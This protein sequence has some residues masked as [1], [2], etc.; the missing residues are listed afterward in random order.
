MSELHLPWLE[1]GILL[2][3]AGAL[4]SLR[5]RDPEASH[6]S[7]VIFSALALLCTLAAWVDFMTLSSTEAH[8]RWSLAAR[9]IG[10]HLF[11]IDEF[12]APLLPMAALICFVTALATLRTKVRRVSFTLALLSESILLAT[13]SCRQPWGVIALLA[14]GTLPPLWELKSRR[15]PVRNFALHMALFVGLLVAGWALVA[16]SQVAAPSALGVCLLSAALL[17]RSG[18]VPTHTWM[19]DLFEHAPFGSA[20]TFVTPIPG[21]YAAVRLLLPVAPNWILQSVALISLVTA[22][23]AAGMALV[24]RNARRFFC[25]VLLSHSSLVLVGL[26]L[27]TPLGLT[28]AL[29]L[30]ISVGLAL[31]GFGL[32]LRS[33]EA[34]IGPISLTDYHGLYEHTPT[35]AVFFLLTGLASIGFPGTIGFVGS[36]LLVAGAVGSFPLVG[37]AVVFAASLN[38]IA[39]LQVYFRV[40]TGRRHAASVSLASGLPERVAVLTLSLLI[41]AGGLIPQPGLMSRRKAATR[42]ISSRAQAAGISPDQIS[43]D[44]HESSSAVQPV[45]HLNHQT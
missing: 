4:R 18:I 12:S 41:L 42:I 19:T 36:E 17:L 13:F 7:S 14:V 44:V 32:T 3:L 11:V 25:Y 40:F 34:R 1:L 6:R 16:R 10:V 23:Y 26:E 20:L 29:C 21:A 45:P 9:L 35:L 43:A 39:V 28:G 24:Q 22:V 33:I 27:A 30:W 38:G 31:T 37:L 5:L 15:K 2:P 8:D